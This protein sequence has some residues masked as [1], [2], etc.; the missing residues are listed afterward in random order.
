MN[1][2]GFMRTTASFEIFPTQPSERDLSQARWLRKEG[3]L[4]EAEAAYRQ[5]MN[6]QPGLKTP[7]TECFDLLRE[8]NRI[9][10]ALALAVETERVFP[11]EAFPLALKGAALI[12]QRKFREALGAL[13]VAV[14]RDPHLALTWHELGY[15]SYKLGDM[16]RA[17]LALDRAFHLEPHTETLSL[18]GR[19]LRDAGE[20]YAATVAFEAAAHSATHDDQRSAVERE[21]LVTQRYGDFA[22]RKPNKLTG[23]E[24][25]FAE[26][27]AVVLAAAANTQIPNDEELVDAF[28]QLAHDRGWQF[29][30]VAGP[31][32]DDTADMIARHLDLERTTPGEMDLSQTPLL[33]AQRTAQAEESWDVWASQ[34]VQANR[35][36]TFVL[37]HPVESEAP[38]DVVGGL[39]QNGKPLHL[40][41]DPAGAVVMA[42]H[43][44]ASSHHRKLTSG[45]ASNP[46]IM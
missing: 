45:R 36:L 29:T 35:G 22:P 38:A 34:I 20:F 7:W 9:D 40:G 46:A 39:E 14:D 1:I 31:I 32:G 26:H 19:I 4:T 13:E 24:R 43:P 12:E 23:G 6:R 17:M 37:W 30:E 11:E 15:A 44:A 21:I 18:R 42:Q 3:K 28:V 10:D 33:V 25:W 8:A 27:G 41:V 2:F 5:V 16:S